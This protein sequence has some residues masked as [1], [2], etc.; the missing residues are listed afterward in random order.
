MNVPQILIYGIPE[1]SDV[2]HLIMS[3]VENMQRHSSFKWN[4]SKYNPTII[5]ID[6]TIADF[7]S[8]KYDFVISL[9]TGPNFKLLCKKLMNML[10][11]N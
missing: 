5:P 4:I 11:I 8:T 2:E 1:K 10:K 3:S 6:R 7:P 9:N